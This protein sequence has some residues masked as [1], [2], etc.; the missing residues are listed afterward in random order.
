MPAQTGSDN[1]EPFFWL[2][3]IALILAGGQRNFYAKRKAEKREIQRSAC[4]TEP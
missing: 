4:G 3:S 2:D 1:L